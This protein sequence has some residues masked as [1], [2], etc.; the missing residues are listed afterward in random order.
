MSNNLGWAVD[1][2]GL[3]IGVAVK[4]FIHIY[5]I[6][7]ML[8]LTSN[9]SENSNSKKQV[10]VLLHI[11]TPHVYMRGQVVAADGT[12]IDDSDTD[13]LWLYDAYEDKFVEKIYENRYDVGGI[14]IST[15][16]E[17][18]AY[19]AYYGEKPERFG[20]MKI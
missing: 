19:I 13:A 20:S 6:E 15:K 4:G 2:Q 16:T 11:L 18:P 14:A 5:I 17:E 10:L 8:T 12:V 3:V 7:M 1:Q 9:C